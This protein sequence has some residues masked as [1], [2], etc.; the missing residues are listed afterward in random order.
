[1]SLNVFKASPEQI[2]GP[3]GNKEFTD[4]VTVM[5]CN[6]GP[7]FDLSKL[8]FD[9]I[10]IASDADI[11]GLFIRSLLMAFYFKLFP[12]IIYD[13]R[14]FI[15]EPPLYRIDDKKDPFVINKEDYI[16]RYVKKAIKDYRLGYIINDDDLNVEFLDKEEWSNFLTETSQYLQDI[17]IISIHYKI[18]ERLLEIILEEFASK[19]LTKGGVYVNEEISKINIQTLL[20]RINIEFPE[21]YYDDNDKLFKGPIDCKIQ[22]VEISDHMINKS[23][24]LIKTLCKWGASSNK[25]IMLK[26]IKTGS[27]HKVSL[28]G[29]LKILRK[30]QPN[31]LHRFKGLTNQ[32]LLIELRGVLVRSKILQSLVTDGVAD[33]V[34]TIG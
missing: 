29:A 33:S 34:T 6:A 19:N 22:I 31:I 1:M 15:A 21:I 32:A 14:L 23:N 28:L 10:I 11:D 5:G 12:E 3:K 25:M 4:L 26:D 8:Q 17:E 18:N 24:S 7:K 30:Y 27:E 16:A 20:N 9:K 13:G 2:I